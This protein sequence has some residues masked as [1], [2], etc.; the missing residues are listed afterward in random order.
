MHDHI[1]VYAKTKENFKRNLL[2]RTE[3]QNKR[4]T[5][6]DNDPRGPWKAENLTV[7]TYSAT[8]DYP[9]TTPGGRIVNP[10]NGRCWRT[11]K[12]KMEELDKDNRIWWGEDGNNVPAKKSFLS[13]VQQGRV[14]TTMLFREE[15]GDNQDAAKRILSLFDGKPFDT[16]KPVGLIDYFITIATSKD[17]TVLDFFA[18]SATTADSI[19]NMNSKDKGKRKF[20]MVQLP[21]SV[22]EKSTAYRDG[23]RTVSE[24]AKKR[25]N[26]AAEKIKEETK[27]DID[28]GFRVYH[29]D[30]SNMQDV[31]YKPQNY[32]QSNMDLF[33][34]NV[35]ADRTADDLLAQVMLDWG[36]PI[37]QD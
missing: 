4:Y 20:I 32:S 16:P 15:V 35:K 2:P 30:S 22:N 31:Y 25:I 36:L 3:E 19:L 28:Y 14:P 7:K 26:L 10:P 27:A 5:N 34:D 8:Y 11:S 12:E 1:I 13:E 24:I 9:I 18:G 23:Y 17:D 29:L 37:P 6:R 21:E 33:A